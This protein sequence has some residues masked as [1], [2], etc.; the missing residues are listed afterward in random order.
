MDALALSV[1]LPLKQSSKQRR[2]SEA[3]DEDLHVSRVAYRV[4]YLGAV[5]GGL[6]NVQELSAAGHLG[7]STTDQ[8][9]LCQV[10][11]TT[12]FILMKFCIQGFLVP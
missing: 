5:S 9:K 4:A 11:T 12:F 6:R 8:P 1:A 3:Q 7:H 2:I 10:D